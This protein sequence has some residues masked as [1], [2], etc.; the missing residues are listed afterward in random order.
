MTLVCEPPP[1]GNEEWIKV[2]PDR[3]TIVLVGAGGRKRFAAL[4]D[5]DD[6]NRIVPVNSDWIRPRTP[7]SG[8]CPFSPPS[9]RVGPPLLGEA[10]R[11]AGARWLAQQ[12]RRIA[13]ACLTVLLIDGMILSLGF[14][15]L[16]ETGRFSVYISL[17]A[18]VAS[19]GYFVYQEIR[20]DRRLIERGAEVRAERASPVGGLYVYKLDGMLI[21]LAPRRLVAHDST[22]AACALRPYSSVSWMLRYVGAIVF[23]PIWSARWNAENFRN[24][25]LWRNANSFR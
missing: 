5:P 22:P 4:V 11:K 20:A 13:R 7:P 3:G 6:P 16:L 9:E 8:P 19:F 24:R 14:A 18:I 12:R 10:P 25:R 21:G 15:D 1:G 23:A 17:A 2:V